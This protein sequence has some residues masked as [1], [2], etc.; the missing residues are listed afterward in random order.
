MPFLL[1]E[2]RLVVQI[3]GEGEARA[4]VILSSKIKADV[5]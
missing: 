2:T 3:A 4:E 5:F 1:K